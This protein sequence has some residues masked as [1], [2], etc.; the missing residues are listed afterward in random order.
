M[1][2]WL[3]SAPPV[4]V[5]LAALGGCVSAP[6]NPMGMTASVEERDCLARAMYFESK[7]SS[8]D[9]M[10]AVGTVVMNRLQSSK[11]PKTLCGVVGEERQ[12]AKGVLTKPAEGRAFATARSVADSVL[13]GGRHDEVGAA[14][15]F[16]T[17]G[18][19]FPYRNMF[20]VAK[21]GGNV[22]YEKKEPGTFTPVRPHTLIAR[23]ETVRPPGGDR[24]RLASNPADKG[25]ASGEKD[26]AAAESGRR[27]EARREGD[28]PRSKRK[29]LRT[30]E[31]SS[32][33]RESEA[34][35]KRKSSAKVADAERSGSEK[36]TRDDRRAS[37]QEE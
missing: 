32:S 12:F 28:E 15:H 25:R 27:S 24:V 16:H 8:E 7:R 20:Y 31:A 3:A 5:V 2:S 36:P 10:L 13:A 23:D 26:H 11:Y 9:G 34:K 17:A 6:I 19:T 22:F 1:P 37:A 35:Q 14:T 21:A 33:R 4:V 30:A 29:E 18:R